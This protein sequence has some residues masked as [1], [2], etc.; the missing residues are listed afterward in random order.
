M[1]I[2]SVELRDFRGFT[3]LTLPIHDDLT[4]IVG[5][6]GVGKTSLL[7]A[8]SYL[9]H[10][11]SHWWLQADDLGFSRPPNKR[12]DVTSGKA[13]YRIRA[14]VSVEYA[15]T[16]PEE[17]NGSLSLT[18]NRKE[19]GRALGVLRQESSPEKH[20]LFV[21]YR[22]NRGFEPRLESDRYDSM[23][24]ADMR[25]ESLSDNLSAIKNLSDWWDRRDAQEARIH[26]DQQS[27]YRDPQLESIR[28]LIDDM[29]EFDG[30]RFDGTGEQPGLYVTKP[31]RKDI[32]IDQ[33]SSGERVYLILLADLARRLQLIQP[34]KSLN[35][36]PGIVLIDE[37][38]LN[39]HPRW[40]RRIIPTLT[41]TF[42]SC[43]F[44]VTTHSPQVLGEVR[45]ENIK[46]L[47]KNGDREI[48]YSDC[49]TGAYGRDS[50][51]LL[52]GILGGSER[53]PGIKSQL[54][55]LERLISKNATA[56]SWRLIADLREKIEGDSVELNIAEQ[57]LR[58][59]EREKED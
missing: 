2:Q 42:K 36:I 11:L 13:D 28:R 32:H 4:V 53:D 24:E 34:D 6:N 22:Q 7:D 44:I 37:I 21:Y 14:T 55:Q 10:G 29:E 25:A 46:I 8:V 16:A 30:I 9:L 57:R 23:S 20:P 39:L 58:R 59:R 3:D 43:Q 56:D 18:S 40:Q 35:E 26:R 52:I 31:G 47:S 19:N 12:I 48:V 38:E 41:E 27:G 15:S 1:K 54:Q 45:A 17:R 50:N 33:L 51:E 49:G 5:E